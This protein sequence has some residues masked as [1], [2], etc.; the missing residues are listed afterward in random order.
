MIAGEAWLVDEIAA[1]GAAARTLA[2]G[3]IL[4]RVDGREVAVPARPHLW[5]LLESLDAPYVRREGPTRR[6]SG[7]PSWPRRA[8]LS[9][10]RATDGRQQLLQR[11][12]VAPRGPLSPLVR[13]RDDGKRPW[14][15]ARGRC[16]VHA[17]S[18]TA[19][20]VEKVPET[21]DGGS[22]GVGGDPHGP[23]TRSNRHHRA[24]AA[25]GEERAV[26][27]RQI[28]ID[29]PGRLSRPPLWGISPGPRPR[30]AAG[31]CWD[32]FQP[33]RLGRSDRARWV[34]RSRARAPRCRTGSAAPR[35]GSPTGTPGTWRSAGRAS[36]PSASGSAPRSSA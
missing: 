18:E 12:A 32:R 26:H 6:S 29:L 31:R 25:G 9:G 35:P 4:E 16:W 15:P 11:P 24:A 28:H 3:I 21:L 5:A 14:A 30:H 7:A 36:A 8:R 34:S 23:A 22:S 19:Q 2:R 13:H 20:P 1:L 27:P 17:V 33:P 10:S